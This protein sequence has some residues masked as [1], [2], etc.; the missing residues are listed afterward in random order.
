MSGQTALLPGNGFD[1]PWVPGEAATEMLL[2]C[3]APGAR[4]MAACIAQAWLD[5]I[6]GGFPMTQCEATGKHHHRG[7][8]SIEDPT[9]FGENAGSN[10]PGELDAAR[11]TRHGGDGSLRV[12][13]EVRGQKQQHTVGLTFSGLG[14]CLPKGFFSERGQRVVAHDQGAGNAHREGAAAASALFSG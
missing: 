9:A 14:K 7:G 3:I 4:K 13:R 8:R 6:C 10:A 12:P 1:V 5:R 11:R 2:A